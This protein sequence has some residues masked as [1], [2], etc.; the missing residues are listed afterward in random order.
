MRKKQ[1]AN[2]NDKPVCVAGYIRVSS[3]RQANEGIA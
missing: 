2:T 3:A 1:T